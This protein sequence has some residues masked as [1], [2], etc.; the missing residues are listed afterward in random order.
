MINPQQQQLLGDWQR[1]LQGA[2]G[3]VHQLLQQAAAGSQQMIAQTPTDPAP[4]R[5]ALGAVGQ[6]VVGVRRQISDS[7]SPYYDRI[8]S[9]GDGEPSHSE[10]KRAMRAFDRWCEETWRKF[11]L[12]WT[13]ELLRQMWPLVQQAMGKPVACTRCGRPLQRQ[14]PQKSETITC[15]GCNSANQVMPETIVATY[16]GS[17]PHLFAEQIA[18]DKRFAC[19]RM[20]DEWE[21]LRDTAHASGQER[22]DEPIERLRQREQM[23]KDYWTT[24]AEAKVKYEGGNPGEA[25]SLVDARMKFFYD[26]MNRSDVW[27]QANGTGPVHTALPDNLRDVD[28]WGPLKREQLEDNFMHE[29][30]LNEAKS[31]PPRHAQA[32]QML[33]Y[34]DA[35]HRQQVAATFNRHYASMAGEPQYTE[36]ATRGAMRAMNERGRLAAQAGAASGLLDPIEG[37]SLQVYATVQAKQASLPPDQ[38]QQLLAQHQMDQAKWERVQ[39]GWIDRM[40]KDTS[41][42]VATEYSKAFMNAGQGQYG[43]A[44]QA[45]AAAMGDGGMAMQ[46][47]AGAEPVS[48][49]KYAEISGAMAA[50][51]KQGKDISAGLHTAFNMTAQDFSNISMFWSTKM[52]Q[53]FTLMERLSQLTTH[54]EQQYLR[55]P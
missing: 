1:N 29:V 31:D 10:M 9:S 6:Q 41:G 14:T 47:A 5:N 52:M 43:G 30:L 40:S 18:I 53:D 33:G 51:S 36:A 44:G 3:H 39:K 12:H 34:R 48:L 20:K 27:R 49:E 17:I 8:C 11:E 7:F 54:Y 38:F 15:A 45:A 37:V 55:Q 26:E 19:D 21:N 32:L 28:E 2:S 16:F 23:E 25:Q 46:G 35:M 42:A 13:S 50:W 22:P 24:Y 4:L